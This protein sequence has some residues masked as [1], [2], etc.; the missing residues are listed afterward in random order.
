M[1]RDD[2]PS[3][4]ASSDVNRAAPTEDSRMNR[5]AEGA[6][7][8]A[9]VGAVAIGRNEGDRLEKCLESVFAATERVVYADSGST[10]GSADQLGFSS[11]GV[12]GTSWDT[13][14]GTHG[15]QLWISDGDGGW[16]WYWL[17]DDGKAAA[18]NDRW[19]R[20]DGGSFGDITFDPAKAYYYYHSPKTGATNFNWRPSLP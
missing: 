8:G 20:G 16:D 10:D 14:D 17:V 4:R 5:R 18:Y 1:T 12:G 2:G 15:D 13:N 19:Y 3:L 7:R 9:D 11:L 6:G